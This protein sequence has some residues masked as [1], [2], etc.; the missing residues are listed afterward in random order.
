MT[1]DVRGVQA[2]ENGS[3]KQKILITLQGQW[4]FVLLMQG[5]IILE[6]SKT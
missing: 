6:F 1:A 4:V 3:H 2:L 5:I